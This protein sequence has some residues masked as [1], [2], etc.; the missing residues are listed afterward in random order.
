MAIPSNTPLIILGLSGSFLAVLI[1]S[2]PGSIARKILED[3]GIY[4]GSHVRSI[5][6]LKDRRFC[7]DDMTR[8]VFK[9]LESKR[10][11]FLDD[12]LEDKAHDMV[13]DAR[14]NQDSLGGIIELQTS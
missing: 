9:Q 12:R 2:W 11:G 13:V 7:L 1:K 4:I 10:L 3:R 8:E 5:K 6:D 14:K